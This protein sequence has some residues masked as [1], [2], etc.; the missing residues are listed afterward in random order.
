[1][2]YGSVVYRAELKG[3][4]AS[5]QLLKKGPFKYILIKTAFNLYIFNILIDKTNTIY[6]YHCHN[7]KIN[8]CI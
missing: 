8:I 5:R 2:S 7:Y 4:R 3:L 6:T 1:M